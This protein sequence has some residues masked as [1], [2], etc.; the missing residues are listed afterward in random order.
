MSLA[1]IFEERSILPDNIRL[2]FIGTG[3][4]AREHAKAIHGRG[5]MRNMMQIA[6]GRA[7]DTATVTGAEIVGIADLN[8]EAA[9]LM[10]EMTGAKAFD[11]AKNLI[12]DGG[13]D[14]LFICVPPFAHGE[15]EKAALEAKIPFFCEKPL[16][17][18]EGFLAEIAAEVEKQKLLTSVGYMTRYRKGIQRT[19]ELVK[20]DPPILAYG[21]W[22]GGSPGPSSWS[23][24][25]KKSGGQ[26]HEAATHIVDIARYLFGE[27]D[28]VYAAAALGF[29]KDIPGYSLDDAVTVTIRFK[30]GGVANMMASCSSNAGG[31]IFLNVQS[32]NH[33]FKFSTWDH[34]LKIQ[35]KSGIESIKGESG[36]F[37]IQDQA[38]VDAVRA[39]DQSKVLSS[40]SD[41]VQS[42]RLSLA[43]LQSLETGKPVAL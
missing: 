35:T 29:N 8:P 34:N 37:T 18:D 6:R 30:N 12:K 7:G 10:A 4:I 1:T 42:A 25:R 31:D 9:R 21:G 5:F 36:I 32:L 23:A 13:V 17:L 40:Y 39:K 38:F 19:K 28:E 15:P 20:N 26:F 41:G 27:A 22:F 33:N 2:G 11:S 3:G 43:A 14:A 16:G 24:N